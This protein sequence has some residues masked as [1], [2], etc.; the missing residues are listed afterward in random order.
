M[1]S[2]HDFPIKAEWNSTTV[3]KGHDQAMLKVDDKVA[4]CFFWCCF[5]ITPRQSQE[6]AESHPLCWINCPATE[7]G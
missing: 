4:A 5:R 1:G 6:N 3:M 2:P 7:Q